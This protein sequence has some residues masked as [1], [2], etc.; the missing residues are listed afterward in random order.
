MKIMKILIIYLF[1]KYFLTNISL[2]NTELVVIKENSFSIIIS[3][4]KINKIF[5]PTP[6]LSIK[7]IKTKKNFLKICFTIIH[8]VFNFDNDDI[9]NLIFLIINSI[10]T[11]LS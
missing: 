10:L 5:V 7:N 2:I 3:P 4:K 6:S 9:R 11:H 1:I 8:S